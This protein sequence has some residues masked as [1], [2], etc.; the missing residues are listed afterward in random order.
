MSKIKRHNRKVHLNEE[1]VE[2]ALMELS[3]DDCAPLEDFPKVIDEMFRFEDDAMIHLSIPIGIIP[4]S[5]DSKATKLAKKHFDVEVSM[6]DD[7]HTVMMIIVEHFKLFYPSVTLDD[8]LRFALWT[9]KPNVVARTSWRLDLGSDCVPELYKLRG[10]SPSQN[11][12]ASDYTFSHK[13]SKL[14]TKSKGTDFIPITTK[15]NVTFEYIDAQTLLDEFKD[16]LDFP[17]AGFVVR[18]MYGRNAKYVAVELRMVKGDYA[19]YLPPVTNHQI[20]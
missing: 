17:E 5:E 19:K 15:E 1:V 7:L 9:H 8:L 3:G 2:C 10:V 14:V 13:K 18:P 6:S 4:Y 20:N 11:G 16:A 12:Y